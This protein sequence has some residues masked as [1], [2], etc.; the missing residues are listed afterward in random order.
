MLD[1][2]A[3]LVMLFRRQARRLAEG[4]KYKDSL[5]VVDLE[6]VAQAFET[7][8]R[9]GQGNVTSTMIQDA[10]EVSGE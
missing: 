5:T 8:L 4:R 1:Q 7:A 2:N 9:L 6:R 10:L 3:E